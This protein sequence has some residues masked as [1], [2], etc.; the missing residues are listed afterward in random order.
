MG[1]SRALRYL[2]I[3]A[4]AYPLTA[5]RSAPVSWNTNSSGN[6]NVGANWS[7]GLPTSA[8][9]VTINRPAGSPVV[10]LVG[11]DNITVVLAQTFIDPLWT[12]VQGY[13]QPMQRY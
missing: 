7:P 13:Q 10:S 6:W 3:L 8:D 11:T 9:D 2:A 4:L 5:A 1:T 12:P